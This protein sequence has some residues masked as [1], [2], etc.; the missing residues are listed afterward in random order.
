M[1]KIQAITD[2]ML[3]KSQNITR[4]AS[5]LFASQGRVQSIIQN[6][7]ADFS[8]RI[9]TLMTEHVLGMKSKYEAMNT[10]LTKY[11]EFLDNA[12]RTYEWNDKE[13]AG[14]A[15]KL[16]GGALAGG[17]RNTSG[18]A[19]ASGR[20][21]ETTGTGTAAGGSANDK[22]TVHWDAAPDG[23]IEIDS[24]NGVP[25]Y[26]NGK[27]FTAAANNS[28]YDVGFTNG[29]RNCAEYVKRYYSELYGMSVYGLTPGG[30]PSGLTP[31]ADPQPGDVINTTVGGVSHWA[32]VKEVKDG[33]AVVIEQNTV[34]KSGGGYE[35]KINNSYPVSGS[36]FFTRPS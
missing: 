1:P 4:S 12:A 31:T 26:V 16:G 18:A 29:E 2:E 15:E 7:G 33:Y 14:W 21:Q 3:S 6:L 27:N 5:E 34:Y 36:R 23:E 19:D 28:Y 8:G 17:T 25:A 30:N 20:S 24:F 11:G 35:V 10:T 32:I 13:L 22:A 9:P